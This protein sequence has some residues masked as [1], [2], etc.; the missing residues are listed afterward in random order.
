VRTDGASAMPMRSRP[1]CVS[2][3]PDGEL[4]PVHA[5]HVGEPCPQCKGSGR[6][7]YIGQKAEM[8]CLACGGTGLKDKKASAPRARKDAD[9]VDKRGLI[10]LAKE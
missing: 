5:A 1:G 10:E 6:F 2:Q 9:P 7:Y 4:C 8:T 3:A